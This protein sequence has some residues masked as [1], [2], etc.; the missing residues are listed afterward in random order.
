MTEMSHDEIYRDLRFPAGPANRPYAFI[1]M[2]ATID[3]KILSGSREDHVVDLGSPFDHKLMKR[4]AA[5][6][7]TVLVGAATLRTTLA[8]W[9]PG[10]KTR[11]VVTKTGDLPYESAFFK[12]G[13][14]WVVTPANS[15]IAL[16]AN[17]RLAGTADPSDQ[18]RLR[19]P[20]PLA[21]VSHYEVGE[22]SVDLE[23][24]FARLRRSGSRRVLVLGGSEINAQL[25]RLDLIDE[26]F[27]T[28]APKVK[29]GRDV[30]TYA[31][32]EALPRESLQRYRIV[33]SHVVG[34]EVFLRYRRDHE[35]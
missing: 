10:T 16:P 12:S 24:L 27:V 26:L 19:P 34:D 11:V 9:D 33:E 28:I 22:G 35:A 17:D 2:V 30:P 32:G 13:E 20:L 6:A 14:A 23:A 21:V 18:G 25:L 7:D 5:Q 8:S 4:I 1:D 29:L 3:G 31:D 15:E